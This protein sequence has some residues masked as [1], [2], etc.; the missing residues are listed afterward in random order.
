MRDRIIF[1][2]TK[3]FPAAHAIF[4]FAGR[5]LPIAEKTFSATEKTLNRPDNIFVAAAMILATTQKI[6][7]CVEIRISEAYRV[8]RPSQPEDTLL[9]QIVGE[10]LGWFS[11]KRFPILGDNTCKA[12]LQVRGNRPASY[13]RWRRRESNRCVSKCQVRSDYLKRRYRFPSRSKAVRSSP[14]TSAP[15]NSAVATSHASFSPILRCA[16]DCS[17]AHLAACAKCRP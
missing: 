6:F 10:P 14:T 17:D 2:T 11:S 12:R 9:Q 16:R 8:Q 4:W 7:P 3:T 5:D 1:G 13:R 15:S